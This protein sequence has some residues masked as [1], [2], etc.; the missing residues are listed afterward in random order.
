MPIL[1]LVTLVL[2]V[3]VLVTA[4]AHALET[5]GKMR[6]DRDQYLAVQPIYYPGFTFAGGAE[7]LS[8][9]ALALLTYFGPTEP[10]PFLLIVLA[11]LAMM[12]VNAIYWV[13]T[14][15][16]N[17]FWL[18]EAELAGAGKT[19]FSA[20]SKADEDVGWQAMR[21]RWEYSHVARA[22]FALIAFLCLAVAL[23]VY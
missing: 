21:D 7:P 17:S 13:V 15:P 2:V 4:L 23:V 14:H 20:G 1:E 16:V 9:I 5:P 19:F 8:V 10:T 6:L 3:L 11:L 22:F 18:K 12:C